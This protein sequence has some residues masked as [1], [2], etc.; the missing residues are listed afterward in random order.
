M[1]VGGHPGC[2]YSGYLVAGARYWVCPEC[3]YPIDKIVTD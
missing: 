3:L 1:C 2:V